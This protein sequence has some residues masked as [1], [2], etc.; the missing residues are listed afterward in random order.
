MSIGTY[1]SDE[2]LNSTGLLDQVLEMV[3]LGHQISRVSV[4]DVRVC[5]ID[6]DVLEKVVPH[7]V[8]VALWMISGQSCKSDRGGYFNRRRPKS[9]LASI[10]D[11]PTYSSMLN[12]LTYLKETL[13]ALWYSIS[14]WYM[15]NGVL[16]V[17]WEKYELLM[18]SFDV[19]C[20]L[21]GRQAK[22][23]ELVRSRLEGVDALH[24]ILGGPSTYLGAAVQDH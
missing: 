5:R 10:N 6:V 24:H 7:K 17:G 14:F 3:A 9:Q 13:P 20:N 1:T 22:D 16:P 8:M 4:Q 21:T 23:K 19:C 18:G 15:P 11:S 12:V 2:Q